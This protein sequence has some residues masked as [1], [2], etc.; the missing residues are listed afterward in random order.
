MNEISLIKMPSCDAL[1]VGRLVSSSDYDVAY[2]SLEGF[3][4][5][6]FDIGGSV[7]VVLSHCTSCRIRGSLTI[8]GESLWSFKIFKIGCGEGEAVLRF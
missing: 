5:V 6:V 4:C 8:E 7:L 3:P 2:T 1:Q